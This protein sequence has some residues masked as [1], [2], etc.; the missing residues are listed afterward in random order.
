MAEPTSTQSINDARQRDR[1]ARSRWRRWL[2]RLAIALLTPPLL[3]GAIVL[4]GLIP[5]NR[6]FQ[7]AEEG[8]EIRV[9]STAVH[10]DLILPVSNEVIDWRELFPD[11]LFPANTAGQTHIA[12]GWG[13][14]NFFL[15]TPTWADLTFANAAGALLW[16]SASCMH[17]T[18]TRGEAWHG[19]GRA[20]RIS[21][22]QYRALVEFI[23]AHL[24]R[25]DRQR[26]IVV[27]EIHYG[28]RD[29]FLEAHGRYHA[30][31][32]CNSWIG[33]ALRQAEVCVPWLTPLPKTMFLWLPEESVAVEALA[34]EVIRG[35]AAQRLPVLP[36]FL[37]ATDLFQD[38][39]QVIM[40]VRV[41]VVQAEHALQRGDRQIMAPGFGQ[42][43]GQAGP[44]LDKTIVQ[45]DG[46]E[47]TF[48]RRFDLA[49][50]VE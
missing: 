32:T 34:P 27:P 33:Q 41:I 11:R 22:E 17:V 29:I 43:T 38:G 39:C 13:E 5:V 40:G 8:I 14:R 47:V 45:F 37:T 23:L 46:A 42:H 31:N 3:Y 20:V 30:L 16:P 50:A 6:G 12:I 9:I 19:Q 49:V 4:V 35:D 15:E 1:P 7:P 10:A 18:M 25:D 36:R 26:L 48:T 21:T 24:K 44:R 28:N 2:R